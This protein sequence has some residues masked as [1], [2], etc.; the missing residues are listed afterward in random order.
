MNWDDIRLFNAVADAGAIAKAARR[1]GLSHVT[2]WRRLQQLEAAVGVDLFDRTVS[3]YS[4]SPEGSAFY[5]AVQDLDGLVE[6]GLRSIWD[7][8]DGVRGTVNVT[9]PSF[10]LGE[11]IAEQLPDLRRRYPQLLLNVLLSGPVTATPDPNVDIAMALLNNAPDGFDLDRVY[12]VRH[13]LY[14]SPDYVARHGGVSSIEDLCGHRFIDFDLV[15]KEKLPAGSDPLSRLE[16]VAP[17][18]LVVFRSSSPYARLAAAR[19]GFGVIFAPEVPAGRDPELVCLADASVVGS[20]PL[21]VHVNRSVKDEARVKVSLEFLHG[22]LSVLP[23]LSAAD[24]ASAPTVADR[25]TG[26]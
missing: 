18:L 4:L 6:T 13:G 3:G 23:E 26:A 2:V 21:S 14:A 24:E 12:A 1:L 16:K 15:T 5:E 11:A 7:G 20:I 17:N 9:G 8:Q 10:F 25:T 22:V 19:R